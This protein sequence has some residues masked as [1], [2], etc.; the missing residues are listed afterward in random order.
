MIRPKTFNFKSV[1]PYDWSNF[2]YP[3]FMDPM[4]ELVYRQLRPLLRIV[5]FYFAEY[6]KSATFE[7]R[8]SNKLYDFLN[9]D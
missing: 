2:E 9:V 8:F 4:C 6:C 3:T 1:T 5:G 7:S